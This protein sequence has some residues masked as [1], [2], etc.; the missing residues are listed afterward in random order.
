MTSPITSEDVLMHKLKSTPIVFRN[1]LDFLQ[2][3]D[4]LVAV[5]VLVPIN[6]IITSDTVRYRWVLRVDHEI[7]RWSIFG[8]N[9]MRVGTFTEMTAIK[10]CA[11]HKKYLELKKEEDA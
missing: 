6:C 1:G 8:V 4:C 7:E 10:G 9:R 2:S 11:I 5:G 3:I